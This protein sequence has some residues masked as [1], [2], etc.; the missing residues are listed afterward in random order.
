MGMDLVSLGLAGFAG[1]A[2]MWILHRSWP[3]ALPLW[4]VPFGAA[5]ALIAA[6]I[7]SDYGWSARTAAALPEGVV[8]ADRAATPAPHRPWA[9][10]VP[11]TTRLVAIDVGGRREHQVRPSVYL[12]DLY[13]FERWRA[14]ER[15][16]V[17]VDCVEGRRALPGSD[18]PAWREVDRADPLLSTLCQRL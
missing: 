8:V 12:A 6:L 16:E 4:L 17:M 13:V 9:Y 2:A 10:F 7:S 14:P 11:V 18:T 3:R 1:A 15:T 5:L